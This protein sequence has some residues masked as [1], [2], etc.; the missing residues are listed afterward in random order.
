VPASPEKLETRSDFEVWM[1]S[2]RQGDAVALGRILEACRP[3]LL[4]VAN[5]ELPAELKAKVGPSDLVQSTFVKVQQKLGFFDGNTKDQLLAWLRAILLNELANVNR[6][7]C[8]TN[9]RQ[10][11]REVF[12]AD[13]P[14]AQ[15][16]N[17]LLDNGKSPSSLALARERDERLER[18]LDELPET[19]RQVIEWRSLERLPFEEIGLRLGQRTP[20]A[21]RQLWVRAIDQLQGILEP[22][23]ESP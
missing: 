8:G 22:G 4:L 12:L 23:D 21:A 15:L 3:Y 9:M 10:V 1:G 18:A 17:R 16:R 13:I 6:H 5:R 14:L 2:A 19:Y 7:Y 11:N 20:A